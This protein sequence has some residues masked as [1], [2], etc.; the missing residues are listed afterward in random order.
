MSTALTRVNQALAAGVEDQVN[1]ALKW[2]LALPKLLLRKPRRGG[3][4]GQCSGELASR[5]EAV[6]ERSW[7]SLLKPL[8]QDEDAERR[9]RGRRVRNG[10]TDID[11]QKEKAQ[12][13]KA[14]LGLVSRGMVGKA[15]RLATSHGLADMSDPLVKA[16]VLRKYPA[17]TQAMPDSVLAGTC[18]ESISCLRETLSNLKPGVSGGFGGLRNEHLSELL[19]KT[20]MR[21][22]RVAWRSSPSAI[23]TASFHL[24]GTRHGGQ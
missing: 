1:R 13:R 12:L 24:G 6:R 16:A 15:R 23:S 11:A 2:L 22:R 21:G 17:R 10:R 18:L 5:F 4:R 3:Q 19:P 8:K 7:G 14:V 9:R 20:G